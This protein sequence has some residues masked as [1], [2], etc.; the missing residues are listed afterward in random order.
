MFGIVLLFSLTPA[1]ASAASAIDCSSSTL[2]AKS[3]IQCGECGASSQSSCTPGSGGSL[4]SL[5]KEILNILSVI[6]GIAAIIMIIVAGLRY[7]T[8]AGEAE[9]VKGAKNTLLYAVI[10]LIIVALA[11]TITHFVLTEATPCSGTIDKNGICVT[12]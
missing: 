9:K 5:V 3:A 1:L 4:D 2:S 10:G 12:K 8:S 11:Q 7:I 6:V